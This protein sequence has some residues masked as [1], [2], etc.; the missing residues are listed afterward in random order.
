ME[1]NPWL[2]AQQQLEKIATLID[3]PPLLLERLIEPDRVITVSLPL[4][5]DDQTT[6]RY[7]GYRSQ[8]NNILGP[9]KGGIRY[10]EQVSLDEVKAL[11]FWMTIK[12]AVINVPFG[13][14]KGGITVNPKELSEKELEHLSRL[15]I[16]R[17]APVIGPET[18]VPAPDV[19][20][21]PKIMSW[22]ADEYRRIV[23]RDIPA[24]ITG[25][26]VDKGGSL[27]RTEA[28]GLGG[29][30][31]LLTSLKNLGKKPKD[32]TVAV[33]GFGNVGY[34]VAHFLAQAGCKIIAVSDSKEGIY[35]EKGL[36]PETTLT[37]KREKG[38]LSGCYCIGSVCD[39]KNGK[40]I[41]NKALLELPVDILIPA[42]LENVITH[43]N[44]QKIKA[45]IILEMANGPVTQEADKI[46]RKKGITV[47]P[48]IL[49][50][51]G[52]VC[53]SY[54]EWY[55]N[56]QNI[57]WTKQEVFDKLKTHMEESVSEMFSTQKKYKGTL[58]DSA[59]IVALERIK[60]HWENNT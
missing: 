47:I 10:H 44:A 3:L 59:Y 1:N 51:A 22:M 5:R 43:E 36:N 60:K 17:I 2:R 21:N 58:R 20:T 34:Y 13:G 41:S 50:N 53:V 54:F 38:I 49:A 25:K 12:C 30:Y 4:R 48:D 56:M 42:A 32:V 57:T 46:L 35:V 14:G 24:V 37:C 15:F 26:P 29:T 11:S 16:R 31:A 55:Q 45:Q 27:G 39:M 40:V 28:T 7:T 19:N 33:Q 23:G 18:D 9:Y 52:G 6:T 8:H